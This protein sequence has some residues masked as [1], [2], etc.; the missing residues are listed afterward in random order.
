MPETTPEPEFPKLEDL[1]V[2]ARAIVLALGRIAME[3]HA[4]GEFYANT[5]GHEVNGMVL[6]NLKAQMGGGI[7]PAPGIIKGH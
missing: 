3:L 4:I 1:S 7:M 5:P 2:D 6:Q